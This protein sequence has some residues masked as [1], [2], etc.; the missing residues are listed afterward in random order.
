MVKTLIEHGA[1]LNARK[2]GNE[3][4]LFLATFQGIPITQ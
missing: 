4:A 1:D 3:P 2:I